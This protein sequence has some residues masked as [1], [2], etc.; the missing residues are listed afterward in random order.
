MLLTLQDEQIELLPDHAVFLPQHSAL[1]LS[2]VHLGKAAAFRAH[3][4]AVP[5]GDNAKD[6]QRI[7]SLLESTGAQNLIIAG[8]FIHAPESRFPELQDWLTSI[9]TT[10]QIT[11]V[12]LVIG[13]HDRRALPA[14]FPIPC[15]SSLTL[16]PIEIIHDPAHATPDRL[17]ICGHIHP[18][19]HIKGDLRST[20]RSACFHLSQR[21][22]T[23]TLPAF[24][25][26]TGGQVI[27]PSPHDRIF[28][29]LK[30]RVAEIP[31]T[32]WSKKG[33]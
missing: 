6:L 28:V 21:T 11:Q 7:T 12:T 1:I 17:S 8:D 3:G 19:I 32:H 4:L 26:F 14:D 27:Q 13:N 29:P 24:G 20:I 23:L 5:D 22:L 33:R 31:A 15:V 30:Q 10:A 9:T 25:T 2:D 16:G 18:V